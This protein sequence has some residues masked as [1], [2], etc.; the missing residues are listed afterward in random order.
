[1][2]VARIEIRTWDPSAVP[3]ITALAREPWVD[4]SPLLDG[5]AAG[6][7]RE[8]WVAWSGGVACGVLI[9]DPS[10]LG[11][12]IT[13]AVHTEHRRVGIGSEVL[14]FAQERAGSRRLFAVVNEGNVAACAFFTE[15]GFTASPSDIAGHLRFE[16]W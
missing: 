4:L 13:I 5:R 10:E 11:C 14:A 6:S 9:L 7:E 1:M 2:Q 16:R 3:L 15:H 8:T 12:E